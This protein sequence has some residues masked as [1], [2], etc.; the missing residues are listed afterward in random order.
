MQKN[1]GT[2][3][4]LPSF[5]L[6][7]RILFTGYLMVV[8]IG[9]VVAGMQVLLTH[10]MADGKKGLSVNDVIYSYYGNRNSSLIE[11]KLNGSMKDK[12]SLTVRTK[13]IQWVRAGAPK[14]Q[15]EAKINPL[16]QEN[17]IRC[18]GI[19]PGLP[20][21]NYY[22]AV[23]AVSKI[24]QGASIGSLTRVS[25]IHLFGIA[26]IFFFMGLIFSFTV[27][28][29]RWLKSLSI[30]MPF[31]FLIIDVM[32]WWL[33]KLH[34]NFAWLTIIGGIGYM[35]AAAFMW[36]T[37]MYQMWVLPGNGKT[38]SVNGWLDK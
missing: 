8:G 37:A 13:I 9:L 22:S 32:S 18:H 30:A 19:I 16:F 10:G 7:V 26:F 24:D 3:L 5:S 28:I 29:P 38:Y 27:G 33:T 36:C 11:T 1:T 4:N 21:F 14:A 17:C 15:W 35:L 2:W 6:P 20:D 25:H 31:I 12:A 23:K 34:P